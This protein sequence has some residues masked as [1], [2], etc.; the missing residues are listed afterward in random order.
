MRRTAVIVQS[1]RL[2]SILAVLALT[3]LG[4]Q[5]VSKADPTELFFSEYI[6]GTSN[7]KAVEF[8]NGTGAAVNLAADL[9]D[10]Q[11][12]HNGSA[13]ATFTVALTGTVAAGD[14]YVLA[15]TSANATIL[16]QADQTSGSVS[17]NGNDAVVLRKNGVIIDVIGQIGF[18]PTAAGWGTDPANT[19]DN[20]LRRKCSVDAGDPNGAD[21]FD[22][23][24][25]WDGFA[26][27]TFGGLGA[28]TNP[29][30]SDVAPTVSSTSPANGASGVSLGSNIHVIFS[31][32]VNVSRTWF[33]ID[34]ATSGT[35]T[36]TV[37][38]GPSS[39]TLDP[40]ADYA[41]SETCT[42]TIFAAQVTDQDTTDPPDTMTADHVFSFQTLLPLTP[43]HDI[44][45]AAHLSPYDGMPVQTSGIVTAKRSNG[46]WIQDPS[47][48]ADV[49]TSEGIFVFTSSAPTVLLGDAVNVTGT[50]DEFRPGGALSGNLTTTE[51]TSPS[52]VFNSTGNPLPAATVIGP[53][54]R[55]PPDT[56]IEDDATGDVETSGVFDPGSDGIDFY[57]SLESMRLQVNDPVASGPT[58]D[59]G[60]VSVLIDDGA[61]AGL[62]TG[63][64]GVIIQAN[65]FNP[66]RIILDDVIA[67]TPDVNTGDHFTPSAFVG[68]L[69]YSF[70]NFKLLPTSALTGVDEGL[71]QEVATAPTNLELSMATFN[72]E[73]LDPGDGTTFADLADLIVNHLRSPDLLTLEEVQDNNGATNDGVVAANITLDTLVTAITTAGGPTYEWRQIDPVDDQDGGEPGGNIRVAFLFRTDRGLS[74]VDRPGGN[75]TTAVS[76]VPGASGP[77]LSISPGRIDPNNAAFSTSRKPLAGEF[78]WDG[79]PLFVVA[80]HWNSKG[81]DQPLFGQHQPPTLSSETQRTQQ[82]QVVNDFVDAVLAVDPSANI[83]IA[84]DL[85]DFAFSTPL[86][87]LTAGG[88]LNQLSDT[89]PA[90]ER[91]SYVFDGNSQQLDHILVSDHLSGALSSFDF[92]HVN[93]EFHDQVSDHDPAYAL[94]GVSSPGIQSVTVDP[95]A[96]ISVKRNVQTSGTITCTPSGERFVINVRLSQG[97]TGAIGTGSARGLCTGGTVAWT[98]AA[99]TQPGPRFE[100]GPATLCFVA[101]TVRGKNTVIDREEGCEEVTLTA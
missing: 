55:V 81:G 85:N 100:P 22:P 65:D 30:P 69:D 14:V 101:T 29:C 62:R 50:V 58:N 39:F 53:G 94:F 38:G 12:Y 25:E 37:S 34:C 91:Y 73:N 1:R 60:E 24:A 66:E 63:R 35:H 15:H 59:F 70:G 23:A 21:A 74:F 28:H 45:A 78:E 6:E 76:V 87:T 52:V 11:G 10:Y 68:V 84:G 83:V 75:A 36:A 64:G 41:T 54:G 90:A 92:V 42:V 71:A 18:D 19:T 82:A 3:L 32:P 96:R 2:V 20:T 47:P 48:D 43:I 77:E 26:V 4:L 49:A 40:D 99:R 16:A 67:D 89:L 79:R 56:V 5:A 33:D 88:V 31:E 61:A 80:N 27:D 72:V 7:N 46:F 95:T 93:S 9:Y 44:Q 13:T 98:V 57:E 17:F 8:Y 97:S 86:A 51:I